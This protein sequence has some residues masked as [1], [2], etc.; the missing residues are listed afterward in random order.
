MRYLEP[1]PTGGS[2]A[3]DTRY[4]I[5]NRF[6]DYKNTAVKGCTSMFRLGMHEAGHAVGFGHGYVMPADDYSVM[7][8]PND[9]LCAL[10]VHDL[11]AVRAVYESGYYTTRIIQ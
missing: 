9:S 2:D 1:S 8:M 4:L 11:F 7:W 10:T 5:L 6:T 3:N